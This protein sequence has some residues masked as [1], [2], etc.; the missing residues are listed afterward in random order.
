VTLVPENPA[1]DLGVTLVH[2]AAGDP[3]K[4]IVADYEAKHLAQAGDTPVWY[5]HLVQSLDLL[6]DHPHVTDQQVSDI[7]AYKWTASEMMGICGAPTPVQGVQNGVACPRSTDV[8]GL[9]LD[10]SCRAMVAW[11][12]SASASGNGIVTGKL[13]QNGAPPGSTA[14]LPGADP[15][16]FV[17][18]QVGG[19][20]LCGNDASLPG[21]SQAAPFQVPSGA[22]PDRLAPVSRFRGRARAT[23]RG[24]RLAGSSYDRACLGGRTGRHSTATLR[25]IRVAIAR[26]LSTRRCRFMLGNGRFGPPVSCL[27]TTYITASG[28][29]R[30]TLSVRARLP[31]GRYVAWVRGVDAF[32]NIERKLRK[33]NLIRFRVR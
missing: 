2:I 22:C 11:P 19:P 8:W 1:G 20:D 31:R 15:G 29:G 5:T 28:R 33:R 24:V 9:A 6:S 25:T 10:S 30:W 18:T 4:V 14:G 26:R 23:R 32:G 7:P 16:T 17:T 3:G 27:R 13:P 21:G 12:T